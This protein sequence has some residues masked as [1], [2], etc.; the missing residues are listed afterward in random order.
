MKKLKLAVREGRLPDLMGIELI[1]HAA[2]QNIL[3]EEEADV[4]REYDKKI[5]EI[6]NVDD[7]E[8]ADFSRT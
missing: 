5:M 2:E 7:F 1:N 4:L 8:F 6:I 3:S